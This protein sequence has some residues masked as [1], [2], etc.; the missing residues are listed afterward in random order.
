MQRNDPKYS[1][2]LWWPQKSIHKIVAPQKIFIFLKTPK[3]IEIQNFAQKNDPTLATRRPLLQYCEQTHI[4]ESFF[5]KGD[6]WTF[7]CSS[8]SGCAFTLSRQPLHWS[9]TSTDRFQLGWPHRPQPFSAPALRPALTSHF[10]WACS[11]ISPILRRPVSRVC[12][13][14]RRKCNCLATATKKSI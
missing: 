5:M 7:A 2:I 9:H 12:D 3:N 6:F 14:E 11:F 10:I 1:L 13:Q 8:E 4:N